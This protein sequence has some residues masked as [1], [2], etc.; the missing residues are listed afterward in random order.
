MITVGGM[1]GAHL[2]FG[3]AG[4]ME[5]IMATEDITLGDMDMAGAAIMDMAG[6]AIMV[7]AGA[8][9][10]GAVI[11]AG[12]HPMAIHMDTTAIEVMLTLEVG[13]D[14]TIPIPLP[15]TRSRFADVRMWAIQEE[16]RQDIEARPGVQVPKEALRHEVLEVLETGTPQEERSV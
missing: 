2:G 14:I 13:A 16:T 15:E 3:T 4:V 6:V 9:T 11:T 5:V 12:A 10:D 1:V 8:A 7:M